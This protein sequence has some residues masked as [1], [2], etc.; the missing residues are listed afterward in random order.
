MS[1]LISFMT[2][3]PC[4]STQIQLNSG[5]DTP[6][7]AQQAPAASMDGGKAAAVHQENS[8]FTYWHLSM[9]IVT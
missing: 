1:V 6:M 2:V 3:H 8:D 5:V 7:P 4:S 9:L